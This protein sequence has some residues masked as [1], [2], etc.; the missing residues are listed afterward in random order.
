MGASPFCCCGM[1][2]LLAPNFLGDFLYQGDFS[3]LLFFGELIADF[4]AGKAA[5]WGKAEVVEWNVLRCFCDA[6]LY[7]FFVLK[8]WLL[9][10]DQAEHDVFAIGDMR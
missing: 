7:R 1:R 2:E 4:A 10:S 3:P 5:L 9:G 6:G 8:A